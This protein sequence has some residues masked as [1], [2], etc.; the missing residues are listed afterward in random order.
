MVL[1]GPEERKRVERA[2]PLSAG[3]GR[4]WKVCVFGLRVEVEAMLSWRRAHGGG[5]EDGRELRGRE[6]LEL[7]AWELSREGK[8]SGWRVWTRWRC[9]QYQAKA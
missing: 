9:L 8:A 6:V 4:G 7:L 5:E 3:E 2:R 1:C